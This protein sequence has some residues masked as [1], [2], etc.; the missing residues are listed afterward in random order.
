MEQLREQTG[1]GLQVRRYSP[2]D[3]RELIAIF[4]SVFRERSMAEWDWLFRDGPD[5]PAEILV[6]TADDRV[7]GGITHVPVASFVEGRRVRAA[8]GCDLMILPQFRGLGGAR[9]LVTEFVSSNRTFDLNFGVVNDRS[10]HLTGRYLGTS[11]LGRVPRWRRFKSRGRRR[12]VLLRN[13]ASIVERIYGAVL[14]WPRPSLTTTDLS[15]FDAEVDRLA[16]EVASF[17]PCVRVRDS[18]YLR[19]HWLQDPRHEWRVRAVRG[20][21]GALRGVAVI[22]VTVEDGARVGVVA[23]LIACDAAALRALMLDAWARLVEEDC[24]SVICTYLDP[25]PWSTT[26][27]R[28][29]GFRRCSG[30]PVACGPLSSAIGETVG[31]LDAWYLTYGDTDI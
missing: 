31:R 4:S 12:N 19:W 22:G 7:V 27:M 6:L 10:G 20:K 29:S 9:L 25:R 23:D 17:A 15:S 28:R 18:A 26:A 21:D 16:D 13:L 3:E 2:G 8:I 1:D 11:V 5:G 14:S 30:L 24:N